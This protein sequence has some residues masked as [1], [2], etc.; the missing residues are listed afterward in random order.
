MNR[1]PTEV[2]VGIYTL[3][4]WPAIANATPGSPRSTRRALSVR[5]FSPHY[6]RRIPCF[7]KSN[8]AYWHGD[9]EEGSVEPL[10]DQNDETGEHCRH[11][12]NHKERC[13]ECP[14]DTN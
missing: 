1:S 8:S 4:P 5:V 2:T 7:D 11:Q 9:H 12:D 10:V 13:F 14:L 3:V 6:Q